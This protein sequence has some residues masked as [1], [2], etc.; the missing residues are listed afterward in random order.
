MG[1]VRHDFPLDDDNA[2]FAGD[3][4]VIKFEVFE[5]D[6][7]PE[8]LED[9]TPNPDKGM[10]DVTSWDFAFTL[11]NVKAGPAL[12]TKR[13]G[14]QG[15]TITGSFNASRTLNTQRVEVSLASADTEDFDADIY[16]HA[17]KRMN[18]GA[19]KL[20]S[21]GTLPIQVSAAPTV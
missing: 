21:Y 20:I 17:L 14:G 18:S 6:G 7:E 13:T 9:G 2:F 1:A 3:D 15:I 12:V 10:E 8:N 5:D 16:H 4:A 19:E 11:A